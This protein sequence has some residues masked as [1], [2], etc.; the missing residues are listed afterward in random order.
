MVWDTIDPPRLCDLKERQSARA[1]KP[2][3]A[4]SLLLEAPYG[5]LAQRHPARCGRCW[6]CRVD[7][8]LRDAGVRR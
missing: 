2:T 8:F 1:E 6:P 4:I 5:C 7:K 3:P